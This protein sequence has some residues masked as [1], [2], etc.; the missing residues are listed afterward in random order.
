MSTAQLDGSHTP[1]KQGGECVEYQKR[2]SC[3]TTNSLILSDTNGIPLIIGESQSGN[4]NDLY[5]VNEIINQMIAF[6]AEIGISIEGVFMNADAGFDCE[7][8]EKNCDEKGIQ[9]NVKENSR[10]SKKEI[11]I[12]VF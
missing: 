4:H 9:L 5:H 12:H 6:L 2:K 1:A 8:F 3:K 7:A 10:G 11:K